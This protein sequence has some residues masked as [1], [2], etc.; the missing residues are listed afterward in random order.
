MP[1]AVTAPPMIAKPRGPSRSQSAA[2]CAAERRGLAGFAG[3]DRPG[4]DRGA[5]GATGGAE[6]AAAS[7]CVTGAAV[8]VVRPSAASAAACAVAASARARV[9]TDD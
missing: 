8:G 5:R 2:S 3:I 6:T 1:N 7:G 4:R 9:R